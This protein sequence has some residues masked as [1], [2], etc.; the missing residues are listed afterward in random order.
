MFKIEYEQ[1]KKHRGKGG[2]KIRN[3]DITLSFLLKNTN[4]IITDDTEIFIR[5]SRLP[6]CEST[7]LAYGPW[8]EDAVLEYA[9]APICF[10]SYFADKNSL[11]ISL[12]DKQNRQNERG[13]NNV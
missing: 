1:F 2:D 3:E 9:D 6:E 10:F 13:T 11:H 8:F 7:L 5:G 4:G 12:K